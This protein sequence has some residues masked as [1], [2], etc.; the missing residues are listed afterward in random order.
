MRQNKNWMLRTALAGALAAATVG[1]AGDQPAAQEPAS[2]TTVEPVPGVPDMPGGSGEAKDKPAGTGQAGAPGATALETVTE[3]GK[4][5]AAD[6]AK[7][8]AAPGAAS[9]IKAGEATVAISQ[10]NVRGGPG[11]KNPVKR[12][13]KQGEKLIVKDCKSG[14]CQVGEAEW[15][16]GRYLKQ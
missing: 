14:W 1:C 10:L 15:V 5:S 11:T 3:K 8:V 16:A 13:V 7:A 12:T 2:A 4:P 9:K 6:A